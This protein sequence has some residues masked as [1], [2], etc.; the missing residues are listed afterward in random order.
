[1]VV[2]LGDGTGGFSATPS[3]PFLIGASAVGI[4]V[5]DF[6]RDGT[7]D[8]AVLNAWFGYNELT[9]LLNRILPVSVS[10]LSINYGG[11]PTGTSN[12]Q[13][14]L[15]TNDLS[16]PLT[17]SDIALQ[18]TDTGD[19]SLKSGCGSSLES[20]G[21]CTITVTFKPPV[22]G[23]RT[24]SL[25]ITDNAPAGSQTV[26]LTGV[27]LAIKLTPTSLKFG[28]VTLGR[29][30]SL[31]VTVTNI[32]AA[33]VNITAPGITIVGG[34]AGDYSQTDNCGSTIA[35]GNSCTITVKFTPTMTG[36]R[37]A[38]LELN[39]NGGGSPQK[40]PLSGTGQ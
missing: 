19:F 20:G 37:S 33:A 24:A 6:D 26:P 30:S 3:G 23:T 9:L 21:D 5:G 12:S 32:S 22:G 34:A 29:T 25:V 8:A 7:P 17:I 4:T 28:T 39:D 10:P 36:A 27:G 2:L 14:I 18:G 38:T 11:R 15:V 16:T 31:P 1:L 13:T 35:A 40:V